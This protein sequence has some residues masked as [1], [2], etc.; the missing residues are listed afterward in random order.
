M[1][2]LRWVAVVAGLFVL[3]TVVLAATTY[4]PGSG[5]PTVKEFRVKASQFAFDPPNIS[6]NKGD[7]VRLWLESTDVSH[8]IYVDTYDVNAH[9]AP[10]Q[11]DVVVEF[12]ADRAGK[13]RFRCSETCGPLHPF[14]IGQIEVV[15]NVPY[16]GALAL[17]VATGI[18]T[19]VYVWRKREAEH[20]YNA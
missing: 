7:T 18:G 16:L 17:V 6:V 13:F 3:S 8:G 10:G 15:P 2:I 14:M 1:P 5:P 20:G 4:G 19:L 12:V 9:A 11:K